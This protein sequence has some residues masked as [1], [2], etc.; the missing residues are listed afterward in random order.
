[1]KIISII[2]IG[3]IQGFLEWLPISS[4]GQ[5]SVILMKFLNINPSEAFQISLT[6]HMG[7]ALTSIIVFRNIIFRDMYEKIKYKN[8][9]DPIF[10]IVL[11]S[12]F[13]SLLTGLPAF[14]ILKHHLKELSTEIVTSVIGFFLIITGLIQ[15]KRKSKAYAY[16]KLSSLNVKDTIILGLIQGFSIIPGISRSAIT[17]TC[18]LALRYKG[19]DAFII[20]FIAS[21]PPSLAI[22]IYGLRENFTYE[23]IIGII[24]AFL[25]GLISIKTMLTL[26]RKLKFSLLLIVLGLIMIFQLILLTL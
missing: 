3:I 10:L 9:R 24:A 5:I 23:S 26:S 18:L 19:E 21:I 2:L 13:F 25:T 22:G 16:K 4:S 7:T 8:F 17:I 14:L 20:S 15:M 1:M 11:L 12:P 6:L